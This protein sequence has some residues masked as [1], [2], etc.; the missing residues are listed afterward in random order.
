MRLCR[1]TASIW[2]SQLAMANLTRSL[3]VQKRFA[4]LYAFCLGEPRTTRCSLAS[5]ER[6]K[7]RS[8]RAWRSAS[9]RAT[10]RRT[11]RTRECILSTWARLLL[12]PNTA[13][14]LKNGSRLSLRRSSSRRAR[15]CCSSTRSTWSSAAARQTVRWTPRTCS[16]RPW[17]AVSSAALARRHWRSTESTWRRTRRLSDDSNALRSASRPWRTQSASCEV[18]SLAT[19]LTTASPLPTRHS[20]PPHS[21]LRDTSPLASSL[22][23]RLTLS[24]RRVPTRGCSS[25]ALLKRLTCWSAKSCSWRWSA[26]PC[27]A[28]RTRGAS[29]A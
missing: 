23:R 22:T 12:A 25:T 28:R 20:W 26:R 14:S 3:V 19:K 17:H 24:T 11:C 21:S 15:S 16:S 29:S 8:S 27:R 2:C 13:A 4:V 7:Q 9:W 1:S 5:R 10:C 6:E 18:S